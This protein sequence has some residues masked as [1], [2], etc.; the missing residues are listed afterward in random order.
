MSEKEKMLNGEMYYAPDEEL[1]EERIKVKEMTYDYNLL[2]PSQKKEKEVLI[3]KILGR[4]GKNIWIEAPFQCDYGYN[5][6]VG[7]NFYSNHNLLILD[8]AKVRI[9]NNVFIGPNV[10]FYTAGHPINAKERNTLYEFAN[11]ITVGD[12]VWIGGSVSILPGVTI[13]SNVVIGAG[14]VVIKDI[15][16]NSIAVGNPCKVIKNIK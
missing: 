11:K 8:C 1:S 6:E 13:G 3:R 4:A 5:I 15:P 9:G 7:D 12:D 14:S 16:S 10:S 2:R